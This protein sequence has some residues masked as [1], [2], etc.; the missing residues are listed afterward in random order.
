MLIEATHGSGENDP[1][2]QP[3]GH[4]AIGKAAVLHDRLGKFERMWAAW[5]REKALR[6][7][8]TRRGYRQ[9]SESY[10]IRRRFCYA[11]ELWS[12]LLNHHLHWGHQSAFADPAGYAHA[13]RPRLGSRQKL[14]IRIVLQYDSRCTRIRPLR[15]VTKKT[16]RRRHDERTVQRMSVLVSTNIGAQAQ[17]LGHAFSFIASSRPCSDCMHLV[18]LPL[19]F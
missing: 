5:N 13:Q 3:V 6:R 19:R 2:A 16:R 4:C 1:G 10:S 15:T 9:W 8:A 17:V 7:A 18:L 11:M 12:S 14:K